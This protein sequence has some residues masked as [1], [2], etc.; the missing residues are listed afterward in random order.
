MYDLK[1]APR[2]WYDRLSLFLK[3]L[4]FVTSKADT[5]LMIRKF[6]TEACRVLIYVDDIIILGNSTSA[7][8]DIIASLNAQFSLNDLGKLNY[9]L[10][11]EVS[12]P[13]TSGLF[14]SQ[15]TYIFWL[16]SLAQML[17]AKSI[18]T[19]MVNDSIV[20]AYQGEHFSDPYLYRSI[21]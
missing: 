18:A 17:D 16:L 15:T 3:S 19:P 7:V 14:L 5:S 8:D 1:Q 2:G 6:S 21:V 20:S 11:V 4:G 9:F 12:Y 13:A 10:G